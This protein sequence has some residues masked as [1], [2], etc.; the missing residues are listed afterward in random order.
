VV[1]LLCRALEVVCEDLIVE[2]V[3]VVVVVRA[4]AEVASA[5]ARAAAA[6]CRNATRHSS[7]LRKSPNH[8][9]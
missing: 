7:G 1:L 2:V 6:A 5:S 8:I 4:A 3:V 9:A